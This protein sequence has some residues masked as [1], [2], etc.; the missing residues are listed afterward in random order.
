MVQRLVLSAF[1]D[2]LTFKYRNLRKGLFPAALHSDVCESRLDALSHK[3]IY[4][5]KA[6]FMN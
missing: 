3:K 1:A 6:A 5:Y 4:K 2:A